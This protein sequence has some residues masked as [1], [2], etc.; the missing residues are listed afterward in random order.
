[1]IGSSMAAHGAALINE[2]SPIVFVSQDFDDHLIYR[3]LFY[4]LDSARPVVFFHPDQAA[5][6]Y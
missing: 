2:E 4:E 6:D 1:M 5:P 3:N